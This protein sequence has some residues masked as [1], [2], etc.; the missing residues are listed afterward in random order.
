LLPICTSSLRHF[1]NKL[2]VSGTIASGTTICS[3]VYLLWPSQYPVYPLNPCVSLVTGTTSLTL[4]WI[5][6]FVC[7]QN[8]VIFGKTCCSW[9]W[10]S[11]LIRVSMIASQVIHTASIRPMPRC[12]PSGLGMTA[13]KDQVHLVGTSPVQNMCCTS[14]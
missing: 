14:L 6:K 4:H 5:A 1:N 13:R 12:P 11:D 2:A 9:S 10:I 7:V 8:F 3:V